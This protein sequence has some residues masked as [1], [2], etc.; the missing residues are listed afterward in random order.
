MSQ[1]RPAALQDLEREVGVLLRR[2]KHVIAERAACVHP[3]LQAGAFHMLIWIADKGPVRSTALVDEFH[4]DKGAVSRT[5]QHLCE[6][7][8][9]DRAP[10]PADGRAAL[11]SASPEAIRRLREANAQRRAWV[12][13][14][15]EG[16]SAAELA[17]LAER[18]E[19]YNQAL[20]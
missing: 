17:D 19:R 18:L 20:A 4:V 11:V 7:G 13:E 10:D 5:V 1:S 3:E 12:Q 8:L 15:L 9:L 14:R 16:W 6:L 2:I